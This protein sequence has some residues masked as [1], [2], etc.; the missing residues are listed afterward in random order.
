VRPDVRKRLAAI[1]GTVAHF[2]EPMSRHTTYKVGGPAALYLDVNTL[3]ALQ[4]SLAIMNEEG[5]AYEVMGNGS[6]VLFADAGF[7]GVVLHLDRGLAEFDLERDPAGQHTLTVG[8]ALSITRLLRYAK[9]EAL[10]GLEALGGVPGTVGGAVRMNAGT[11]LGELKDSLLA[12]QLILTN[13]ERRWLGAAELDLS[14]RHSSLPKGSIVVAARFRVTDATPE[15]WLRLEEVLTYRKQTQPLTMPSCGSVFANPPEDS[16]GRLI[17]EAGLKGHSIGGAQVSPKHANW[18]VNTGDASASDVRK[19]IDLCI[20]TVRD[21]SGITL[22]HEVKFHGDW[23]HWE[24]EQ[25]E[26]VQT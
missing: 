6:N 22:R 8:A 16:A 9:D 7:N 14:Y 23:G 13:G 18:I 1:E 4:V 25:V 5:V 2:D 20:T 12:A 24:G 21:A 15:M 17:D 3:D 10:A 11:R 19:L 26:E